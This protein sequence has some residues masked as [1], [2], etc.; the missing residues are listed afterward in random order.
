VEES[1][2]SEARGKKE[3]W[4]GDKEEVNSWNANK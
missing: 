1:T 3:L 2:L 4:E